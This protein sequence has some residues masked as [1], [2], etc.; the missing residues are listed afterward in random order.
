LLSVLS[1]DNAR[2]QAVAASD[3]TTEWEEGRGRI[4]DQAKGETHLTAAPITAGTSYLTISGTRFQ[5]TSSELTYS[6]SGGAVYATALPPGG[7]SFSV[8]FDL[9]VGATITEVVFFVIDDDVS[10]VGVSLRSYDPET[11]DFLTLESASSSGASPSVQAIVIPVDPPVQV[12]PAT[13]S[14]RLRV[15]P[16]VTST[17]HLLRGARIGYLDPHVFGDGFE[18]GDTEAW[19]QTVP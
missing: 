5:P 16:V 1:I 13:T 9:P 19:S 18:S 2:A 15:V 7:F 4:S 10:D 6:A 14:Y 8:D 11:S 17:A 3:A 12:D